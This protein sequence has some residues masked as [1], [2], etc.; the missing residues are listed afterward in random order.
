MRSRLFHPI[1]GGMLLL[2][3]PH[4]RRDLLQHAPAVVVVPRAAVVVAHA[5]RHE[6]RAVAVRQRLLDSATALGIPPHR[7]H[8]GE[9][10]RCGV[11][12][13]AVPIEKPDVVAAAIPWQKAIPNVDVTLNEGEVAMQAF[14]RR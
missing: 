1:T 10:I 4:R 5:V 12:A 13:P 7:H 11:D 3:C 8:A 6:R 9:A 14:G 2:A